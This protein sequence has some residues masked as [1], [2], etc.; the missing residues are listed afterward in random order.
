MCIN[1]GECVPRKLNYGLE[2]SSQLRRQQGTP[3]LPTVHIRQQRG[4]RCLPVEAVA[5]V[6]P[7][8]P[9][10]DVAPVAPAGLQNTKSQ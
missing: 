2:S 10:P 5:P 3:K 8:A 9:S 1:K 4:W 7:V 6:V